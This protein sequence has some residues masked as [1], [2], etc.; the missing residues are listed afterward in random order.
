MCRS[1]KILR[2]PAETASEEEV[3]AAALQFVRKIS[4]TRKPS[5]VDQ[6]AFDRGV[7]EVTAASS[8]LLQTMTQK[9]PKKTTTPKRPSLG[10]QE[11]TMN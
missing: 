10:G 2:Q 9:A 3:R 6:A 11:I 7:E 4:G 8:R 5:R 1:I